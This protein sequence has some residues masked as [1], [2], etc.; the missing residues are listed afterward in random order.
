M[1]QVLAGVYLVGLL[2]MTH[3]IQ[4]HS[5][6]V[7]RVWV[8]QQH[9]VLLIPA[10]QVR[11]FHQDLRQTLGMRIHKIDFAARAAKVRIFLRRF[12]FLQHSVIKIQREHYRGTPG[13]IGAL[14][15]PCESLGVRFDPRV[16]W[17]RSLTIH[18]HV[19]FISDRMNC[20]GIGGKVRQVR[21]NGEI[22]LDKHHFRAHFSSRAN[23]FGER[24][25]RFHGDVDQLIFG[26]TL[27]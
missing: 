23:G 13:W 21:L 1:L 10:L 20:I 9:P 22:R 18:I 5:R 15:T 24:V 17:N 27:V 6:P 11:I 26:F 16:A 7:D 8:I 25:R 3:H 12:H 19:S 14:Q 2:G 4:L